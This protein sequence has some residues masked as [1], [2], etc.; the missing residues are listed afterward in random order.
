[1]QFEHDIIK[2]LQSNASPNWISFF[3]AVTMLGS[4]LGFIITFIIVFIKNKKL[5]V[6]LALTFAIGAIVNR[7]IKGIIA[8]P[9]PFDV[10]EDIINYGLEEGYSFPSGHSLCVGIFITYIFYTLLKTTKNKCTIS[11]GAISLVLLASLV[12]FSRMVLGVHYL[13]DTIMGILLGILFAFLSIL[14]YN[15]IEKNR[16]RKK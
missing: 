9:R 15:Y 14:V 1:M 8:R 12:A 3:Q 11:L 4:F 16:K 5:S 10:Y 7:F 13:S 2:F 6:A